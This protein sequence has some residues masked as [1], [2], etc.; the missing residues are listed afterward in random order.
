M[1]EFLV[2]GPMEIHH[3]NRVVRPRGPMLQT[4]L[5]A[6]LAAGGKLAMADALSE[7]L[8]GATP[9]SKADNALQA[10]I[11]RLRRTLGRLEP[12]REQPRLVTSVC[13]YQLRIDAD[14]LDAWTFLRTVDE[15]RDR[16]GGDPARDVADLRAALELWRGPVFGGLTGG[17]LCQTAAAKWEEARLN[18]LDLLYDRELEVGE[19]ARAIPELTELVAQN[20]LQE[21]FCRLLM[22]ALYRSGRQTDALEVYRQLRHRLGDELGIDPSPVLRRYEQAILNH[23]PLLLKPGRRLTAN[24]TARREET[25]LSA[26]RPHAQPANRPRNVRTGRPAPAAVY[27]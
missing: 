25:R 6:F 14:E 18:A 15:I 13:G 7:E 27:G 4:L 26:A 22:V 9:P 10:Q 5:A 2:L 17:P 19:H 12:G 1:S 24:E 11:S 8:W 20:P 23:D 3:Q 21:Q 16:T